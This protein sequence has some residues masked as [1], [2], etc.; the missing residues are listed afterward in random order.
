MLNAER[1]KLIQAYAHEPIG[2]AATIIRCA[3][4]LT[5][6]AGVALIGVQSEPSRHAASAG[7]QASRAVDASLAHSQRLYKERQQQFARSH[8]ASGVTVSAAHADLHAAEA[9]E[10]RDK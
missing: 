7:P 10:R 4:A 5:L 3:A 6:I 1:A 2:V 9:W 8:V